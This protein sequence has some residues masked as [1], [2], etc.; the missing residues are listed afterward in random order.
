MTR[1][2]EAQLLRVE[3]ARQLLGFEWGRRFLWRLLDDAGVW[4]SSF[5]LEPLAMAH[6]EGRRSVGLALMA[7]LQRVDAVAYA[8]MLREQLDAAAKRAALESA[9]AEDTA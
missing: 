5:S 3:D 8:L 1:S 2:E 9:E 6:A 4:A 7:E